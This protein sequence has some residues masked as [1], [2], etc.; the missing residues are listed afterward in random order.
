MH[1]NAAQAQVWHAAPNLAVPV[2]VMAVQPTAASITSNISLS[3]D[4]IS[5]CYADV[6]SE[7]I[8][9]E[10]VVLQTAHTTCTISK[11]R[12]YTVA[13]LL[14][15]ASFAERAACDGGTVHSCST[16][17]RIS[18]HSVSMNICILSDSC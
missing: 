13:M 17:S 10:Y 7:H 2:P 12:A 4:N 6:L 16:T 5:T 14:Y 1:K 8:Y 18:V 11:D 15:R 9:A 3:P